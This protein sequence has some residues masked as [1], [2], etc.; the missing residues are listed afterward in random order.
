MSE[1]TDLASTP[2]TITLAGKP[3][4]LS[5]ITPDDL[6]KLEEHL[7]EGIYARAK[8]KILALGE[9]INDAGRE[10]IIDAADAEVEECSKV[11]SDAMTKAL[12]SPR[13]AYFMVWLLIRGNAP[14]M[15]L[16]KLHSL[17]GEAELAQISGSL[18]RA[19]K[20]GDGGKQTGGT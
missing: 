2:I 8:R 13:S 17:I 12:S 14:D 9:A 6:G 1:L 11:G 4:E 16:E 3:Y 5:R 15:T 19:V 18:E 10:R 20:V 7:T